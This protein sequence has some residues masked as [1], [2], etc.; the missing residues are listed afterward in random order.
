ME[1]GFLNSPRSTKVVGNIESEVTMKDIAKR[2]KNIDGKI[3][4]KDGKPL[5][6]K[7]GEPKSDGLGTKF[8]DVNMERPVPHNP[9]NMP[10]KSILK[11]NR[12]ASTSVE[13]IG[14]SFA[15]GLDGEKSNEHGVC[16]KQA[17]DC[18]VKGTHMQ[19]VSYVDV[20][21]K[22]TSRKVIVSSL[23]NDAVIPGA[24]I[25]IP[26]DAVDEKASSFDNT[27]YGYFVGRRHAFPI[28]DS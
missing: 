15:T 13:G 21:G 7:H 11:G 19:P 6:A 25:V 5:V 1:K 3:I 14:M 23:V 26:S 20:M 16:I 28:V 24:N 2:I 17:T 8:V 18:L 10:L 12:K 27:L 22:T 4:G 9:K